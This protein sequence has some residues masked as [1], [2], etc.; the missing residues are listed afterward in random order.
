MKMQNVQNVRL[1]ERVLGLDNLRLSDSEARI[2]TS[3]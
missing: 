2:S 3:I 1:V